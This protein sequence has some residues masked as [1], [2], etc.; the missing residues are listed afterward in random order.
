MSLE[1]Y[2]LDPTS[3]DA[4]AAAFVALLVEHRHR[5]FAFILK[6]LSHHADAEDV[7]QRTSL[8]LWKKMEDY[9]PGR[10]F[11]HWACGV[12]FNEVRNFIAT[13]R[14]RR[15]RFDSEL[16]DLLAKEAEDEA[17]LSDARLDA[18][19]S[20]VSRLPEAQRQVLELCYS[21]TGSI[22]EVAATLGRHRD[23]LYKQLERLR[24]T[25]L[26]CIRLRLAREGGG[27]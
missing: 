2:H 26:D 27:R 25:L 1:Q 9:E 16:L 6:Q 17:D 11:F 21:D 23:A 4:A 15:P 13:E 14:R 5:L 18:L 8:V 20:C 22:S 7:F 12:A 24:E 3:D 19:R 10:S